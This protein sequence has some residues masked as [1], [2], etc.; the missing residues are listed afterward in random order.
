LKHVLAKYEEVQE[1]STSPASYLKEIIN[2]SKQSYEKLATDTGL[3]IDLYMPGV[4]NVLPANVEEAFGKL[5][6]R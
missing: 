1:V 3:K 4:S 6:G 5:G 2:V